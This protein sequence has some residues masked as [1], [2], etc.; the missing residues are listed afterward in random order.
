ML[1]RTLGLLFAVW[2]SLFTWNAF[3]QTPPPPPLRLPDTV[4]PV[5]YSAELTIV[6][7]ETSFRGSIDIELEV[8]KPTNIVWLNARYLAVE[9]AQLESAGTRAEARVVPGGDNFVGF[10]FDSALAPGAARLHIE[11]TGEINRKDTAGVFSQREGDDWYAYTQFEPIR[12][13]RAF[14]SF[15]EPG[16]KVP[17]QLALIV[18]AEHVAV[19][20]TPVASEV[21]LPGGMKRVTFAPTP[22]LPSYLIAFGVGPFDIVD[23]AAAGVKPTPVRIITPKGMA[24]QA[25]YAAQ[26]TPRILEL[27]ERYTGIP[28]PYEKLDSLAIPQTVFF[29]AMENPGLITYAMP[30]ILAKAQDESPRFRQTYAH[31]AAHE[32]GHMWF[33]DLVTH[34]WWDDIWLNES[35]ATWFSGTITDRF[36]PSWGVRAGEQIA[37]GAAMSNDGLASARRIRQPIEGDSDIANA[38]D[39]ITYQKGAA[40]L[41]MFEAWMGEDKFGN[42]VRRY[43]AR[44]AHA[45]AGTGDFLAE[46][47]AEDAQAGPAFATFLEQAGV[48]VVSMRLQ[49][50]AAGARLRLAQQRF[51]PLG[52]A[53]AG[54]QL[55]QIPVC[56][57]YTARGIE[58]RACTLMKTAE[59]TLP[60]GAACPTSLAADTARYYRAR[61]EDGA[62][63]KLASPRDAAATVA[64][65]GDA[66]ALAHNGTLSVSD[67]LRTVQPFANSP[68]RHVVQSLIKLIHDIRTILPEEPDASE[69]RWIRGLFGRKARDLGFHPRENESEEVREL[70]P[71]VLK[72]VIDA[73]DDRT[74]GAQAVALAK[75]WLED[76]GAVDPGMVQTVL[77]G[78]ARHGDRELFE[79]YRA[80]LGKTGDRRERNDLFSAFGSFRD[81]ALIDA[82]LGLVMSEELDIREAMRI[83]WTL[84]GDARRGRYAYEFMK[85]NFDALVARLP[86]DSAAQFPYFGRKLCDQAARDDMAIFFRDRIGEYAGGPRNLAQ[87][88][89][90]IGLCAEFK[91][92]Q[93]GNL[94]RFL[95]DWSGGRSHSHA[96][97][98]R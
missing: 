25:R 48:P 56:V 77:E 24:A 68:D 84:S 1:L 41:A 57:R 39:E 23:A 5:R 44:H 4:R 98:A 92:R 30:L 78:A 65:I 12:A 86:R 51:L 19:S 40:V 28:Y 29:G 81:P 52:S 96:G 70:R 8:T 90:S 79:R 22:P 97:L 63:Q 71:A 61:Y 72:F 15:D 36:E 45:N 16:Y 66:G 6:P 49:C 7:G 46:L 20:N 34:T 62:L 55:W 26:A 73:G 53:G 47:S 31:V 33:G 64:M 50:G 75:R 32:I 37:R 76:R 59:E 2:A 83:V 95:Q 13:R 87:M 69:A 14:P 82:A 91:S 54:A 94:V 89:E 10:G 93:Q 18:R 35:F 3:S 58:R 9:R 21:P 67:A 88:L 85:R 74:L 27:S 80:G 60:L 43:L 17:W 42:A 38:F 11:Y